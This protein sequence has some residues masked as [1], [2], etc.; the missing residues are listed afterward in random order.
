MIAGCVIGKNLEMFIPKGQTVDG[1]C[2]DQTMFWNVYYVKGAFLNADAAFEVMQ[3]MKNVDAAN[4]TQVYQHPDTC[5][6]SGLSSG[7]QCQ[8]QRVTVE[9]QFRL[10]CREHVLGLARAIVY[11]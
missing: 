2:W 11:L 1:K 10:A 6:V 7:D 4:V 9:S 8:L 5:Q 3:G